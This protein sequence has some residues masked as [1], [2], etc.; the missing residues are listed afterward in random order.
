MQ[1]PVFKCPTPECN[2]TIAIDQLN[3]V[4]L[5]VL[6]RVPKTCT[7]CGQR[8]LWHQTVVMFSNE[9]KNI[10]KNGGSSNVKS[11]NSNND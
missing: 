11:N 2:N 1:M 4:K 3:A 7:G 6:Q 5:K 9:T 10:N 8:T